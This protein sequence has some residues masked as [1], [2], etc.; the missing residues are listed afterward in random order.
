MTNFAPI[1]R[2]KESEE[3]VIPC[4]NPE[5]RFFYPDVI[6]S[7]AMLLVVFLH[8]SGAYVGEWQKISAKDWMSANLI[9][10]FSR[11][12]VPLFVM[13]SGTFILNKQ[14]PVRVFF[15]KRVSKLLV[16]V[17]LWPVVYL[18]WRKVFQNEELYTWGV[19]RD[20]Y[21]GAVYYHLWFLYM[22]IGLYLVTPLLRKFIHVASDKD[23]GYFLVLWFIFSALIPTFEYG[24]SFFTKDPVDFAIDLP[25]VTG[26]VGL[27]ILG[28][29]LRSRQLSKRLVK[30]T[31]S[32]FILSG[33]LT[34]FGTYFL[35]VLTGSFQEYLYGYCTPFVV[36][37]S[38]AAYFLLK[39]YAIKWEPAVHHPMRV[40]VS[41]IGQL[42]LG[43]Y[44][45]HPIFLDLIYKIRSV[46]PPSSFWIHSYV[47]I[48]LAAVIGFVVTTV[49]CLILGRSPLYLS[50]IDKRLH[51]A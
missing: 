45:I 2:K 6:R 5:K 42:S 23:V 36:I 20:L 48:P 26:Y 10:S 40:L 39:Y 49:V 37:Q 9:D 3:E 1:E 47:F 17:L 4:R 29:Y 41:R 21:E 15:R 12:S 38:V 51:R 22:I 32:I 31:W 18:L 33:L 44:L 8:S 24:L 50:I 43:I 19:L 34:A 25:L 30:W 11:I 46:V 16:P 7:V 35:S 28:Y 13:L 27:F 14:E